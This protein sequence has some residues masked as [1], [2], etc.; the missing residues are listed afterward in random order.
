MGNGRGK[1]RLGR[2]W[3][4]PLFLFSSGVF[5]YAAYIFIDPQPGVTALQ[6]L[7]SAR[8]LVKQ[9][10][11][12][13]AIERL[14]DL[15]DSDQLKPPM[16][17]AANLLMAEAIEQLQNTRKDKNQRDYA[18]IIA[19][20]RDGLEL[21]IEADAQTH[22]RLAEAHE[23]LG[24][25]ADAIAE[26]QKVIAQDAGHSLKWERRIIELRLARDEHE[27]AMEGLEKYLKHPELAR[28]ERAWALGQKAHVLIDKGQFKEARELLAEALKLFGGSEDLS[29][30][31]NFNYWLGYCAWKLGDL[32]EG[33][34]Y[35]R[36]ARDQLRPESDLDAQAAYTL[37]KI[38]QA[39]ADW[40]GAN[41]FFQAVMQAHLDSKMAPFARIGRGLSRVALRDDEAGLGDLSEM[42]RYIREREGVSQKLKDE[43]AAAFAKA[44]ELLTNGGNYQGALEAMAYEQELEPKPSGEFFQRLGKLYE[45]R[46]EQMAPLA[47]SEKKVQEL[48]ARAGDAYI[49]FSKALVLT[50]DKA[51]GAAMWKGIELYDQA[52]DLPRVISALETFVG[53]RPSDP[54]TPEAMLRLGNAYHAAGSLDKAIATYKQCQFLHPQTLA[55]AQSGVPLAKALIA[56]GPEF[57]A[58]AE[59]VLKRVVDS[60]PLI[61]P[62]AREFREALM[63]LAGLYYRTARYELAVAKL[64]EI[65]QRYP[66]DERM[67]Q[68]WFLMADSYRKSATLLESKLDMTGA[69]ATPRPAVDLS[70]A[71][72]AKA[73]RLARA[74]DLYKQV[75]EYYRGREIQTGED[76]LYQKLA[77]FYRADCVYDLGEYLESIKFYDEAASHYQG[78]PSALAAYVQIVNA[79]MALGR[80]DEAK[81]ASER[82]KTMFR[83][84]PGDA[85]SE[86]ET[87][88]AIPRDMWEKWLT[89]SGESG[90]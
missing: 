88:Y 11:P 84:M 12:E 3:Q 58:K 72:K 27:Q 1:A 20:T 7:D 77:Y 50:D 57:H 39:Q 66:N 69:V 79:N 45:K 51:Y 18:R 64:E 53:E 54:L 23:A 78:D 61:T 24:H 4:W 17:G 56:K 15:V 90:K 48:R 81:A 63:E 73:E 62:D 22:R 80:M 30:L 16:R 19:Y 9:E 47:G 49:A 52:G 74:R 67:G 85:F 55:A 34:Q 37:G 65:T 70:D 46:A 26:Y 21:G 29:N 2:L 68:L 25:L 40:A 75:I 41:A 36:I 60:N 43:A 59:E 31:G 38:R 32:R 44:G 82:A 87:G 71:M 83:A 28:S 35:L 76:R 6:M 42:A 14:K 10:R 89:W 86:T 8:A 5:C 33:E 13:A